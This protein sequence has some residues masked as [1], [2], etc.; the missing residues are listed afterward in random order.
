METKLKDETF[1][2]INIAGY[3]LICNNP[4]TNARVVALYIKCD[5]VF[6]VSVDC[7]LMPANV[8][9][10][11]IEISLHGMKRLVIGVIYRHPKLVI[12][13]IFRKYEN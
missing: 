8:E 12:G 2:N 6:S 4:K 7:A 10:L 11:W 5:F 3:D 9:D 1:S 13:V